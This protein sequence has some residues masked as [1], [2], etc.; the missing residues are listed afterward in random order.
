MLIVRDATKL[1]GHLQASADCGGWGVRL[2]NGEVL[3]PAPLGFP[4]AA[5][6]KVLLAAL[7]R[8]DGAVAA[9]ADGTADLSRAAIG[10]I[11]PEYDRYVESVVRRALERAH[12]EQ[13]ERFARFKRTGRG[14]VY[15]NAQAKRREAEESAIACAA[16]AEEAERAKL[17]AAGAE[18]KRQ[19][20]QLRALAA[21]T[22]ALPFGL[23]VLQHRWHP[24][25]IAMPPEG[26]RPVNALDVYA[27]ARSTWCI[28]L[29]CTV[30]QLAGV[31]AVR[32]PVVAGDAIREL[33][34]EHDGECT[35]HAI[36]ASDPDE[37][38]DAELV[39][40]VPPAA[41]AA[42][43]IKVLEA[44]RARARADAPALW[45]GE[46]AVEVDEAFVEAL[47]VAR[48]IAKAK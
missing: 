16:A 3:A 15:V 31:R 39:R 4:T 36:Q 46:L 14:R 20:G 21:T 5:D 41:T 19:V 25:V 8:I 24:S 22:G 2:D 38:P 48:R 27:G 17:E 40:R 7:E 29:T 30:A 13:R 23:A 12:K 1:P 47:A 37:S 34:V 35:L 18:L 9:D 43:F 26:G 6:A 33:I 42:L 11:E 32:V 10:G 45:P 44:E 28:P